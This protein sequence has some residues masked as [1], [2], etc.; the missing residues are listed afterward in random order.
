M[1]MAALQ[2]IG[3]VLAGLIILTVLFIAGVALYNR[4]MLKKEA[5]VFAQP[6]GTSVEVDG[7]RMCVY[8]KGEGRHTLVFLAGSGNTCP[9]LD[10]KSIYSHLDNDHRIVVIEKFGYGMSDVVDTERSFGTIIRQD[11]E[12]LEKAGIEGPFILCPYSMSGVQALRWAQLY[13]EEVEG[14]AGIDMAVPQTYDTIEDRLKKAEKTYRFISF[15]RMS[16]LIR[17]IPDRKVVPVDE[18]TK[19]EASVYRK[20]FNARMCNITVQREGE[21]IAKVRDDIRKVPLPSVPM[22][23]MVSNGQGTGD[24]EKTWRGFSTSF[25]KDNKNIET[26]GLTCGHGLEGQSRTIAENIRSFSERLS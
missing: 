26:I 14:I 7:H 1:T 16:G 25:A 21:G 2:I 4:I 5:A 3:I 19:D 12:A 17:L 24:D 9:I 20:I 23:L 22:I 10:L 13:P 11:R 18:L 6:L 8:A 15:L